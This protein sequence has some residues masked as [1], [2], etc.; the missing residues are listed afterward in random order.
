MID[1]G[2]M[3]ISIFLDDASAQQLSDVFAESDPVVNV[4]GLMLRQ[5]YTKYHPDSGPLRY[6]TA[7]ALEEALGKHLRLAYP[8]FQRNALCTALS[9]RRK[10]VLVT[11]DVCRGWIQKYAPKQPEASSNILSAQLQLRQQR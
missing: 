3:S 9:Q 8:G 7:D 11:E 1:S 6:E 5:W 10:A 4:S 2:S